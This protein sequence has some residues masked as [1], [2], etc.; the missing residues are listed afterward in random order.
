MK[1][2]VKKV[3]ADGSKLSFYLTPS[4][5]FDKKSTS[6]DFGMRRYAKLV[7]EGNKENKNAFT[8]KVNILIETVRWYCNQVAST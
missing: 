3:A 2:F 8:A 5:N 4:P 7:K 1:V 6:G